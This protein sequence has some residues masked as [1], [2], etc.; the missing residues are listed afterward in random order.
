MIFFQG[1]RHPGV[2]AAGFDGALSTSRLIL[3]INQNT[4]GAPGGA[5]IEPSGPA[6][7]R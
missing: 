6:T 1:G 4:I 5:L 7:C 2:P 3:A